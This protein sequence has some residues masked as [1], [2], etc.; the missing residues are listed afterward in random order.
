MARLLVLALLVVNFTASV[1]AQSFAQDIVAPEAATGRTAKDGKLA[2]S[3]MVVA[4][5][6]I[7]TN[8]G[9]E[10]LK[11]GGNAIDAAVAVQLALNQVEPQSSGIGGGSFIVFWDAKAKKLT[12]YD[13]RETAP[14]KATER[15]F[16]RPDG[17]SMSRDEAIIGGHSIG[18]PGTV[19]VLDMA[20]KAH[21][22]L[23][24]AKLF[25]PAINIAENGYA[26]S[27]RLNGLLTEEQ[28]MRSIAPG[29]TLYY[30]ADGTPKSVGTI[31][32]NPAYAK[33]LKS[34]AKKGA[35]EF[36]TG[37]LAKEIVKAAT[38][39]RSP[40]DITLADLK[41]YKAIERAP[42]CMMYRD[43]NICG[44]GPPTSGGIGVMQT[45]GLLERFDLA[46]LGPKSVQAHHL[47]I[48]TGRLVFA[49]RAV[50]IA[51]PDFVQ[52]P[53]QDLISKDYLRTRG[54][55]LSLDKRIEKAD[56]GQLSRKYAYVPAASP[57]QI[58]TSHFS[59]IDAEGN[60]VAMTTSIE[61]G[62]GSRVMVGGFLLNNTLTDFSY[63]DIANGNTVAN[64]VGPNKRPRSSMSPTV[65]FDKDGNVEIVV[66]SPGG[67]AIV[68]F[69]T[70]TL[71][72]LIDWGL[73]PQQ[74]VSLPH[75]IVGGQSAMI[76][77][78]LAPMKDALTAMG[79][80]IRIGEFP[81]G[82][83][84]IRVTKDGL[85]GGADPRREGSVGGE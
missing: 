31:I 25:D 60:A 3:F 57:E 29:S 56:A 75:V 78:E 23:A 59:I 48:D 10:I 65:V 74:A 35:D 1:T 71:I 64:A 81:S 13:G 15:R 69:V 50:Y 47:I 14:S 79:H 51:D 80:Q 63:S 24:W 41:N 17:K 38:S 73:T 55:R 19:R 7:A 6:P 72:G 16:L 5:N 44:M 30:T 52:I 62:F 85:L 67:P 34:L 26:V 18:V 53:T 77:P 4:A 20:H 2:K 8:A 61:A 68:G 11:K 40:S 49:D 37:A 9:V 54:E 70:Q 82:I 84:A 42:I 33:T 76:E 66:G 46:A 28:A 27:P 21:G 22:K 45:L 58:S 43:R 12:T 83:H 32:K 36:Y 39:A